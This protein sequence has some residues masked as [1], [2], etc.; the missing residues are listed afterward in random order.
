MSSHELIYVFSKKGA[1]YYRK[2]I[3]GDFAK[4]LISKKHLERRTLHAGIMPKILD[5]N[6]GRRCALSVIDVPNTYN[7]RSGF[8]HPTQKPD[9]LYKFLIER[10]SK[11]GDT[12]LDATAGSFTSVFVANTLERKAIGIEMNEE[13]F[14]QALLRAGTLADEVINSKCQRDS[15]EQ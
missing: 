7:K 5:D 13:F 8:H 6:T 14:K 11:E 2:D 4:S 12:V 15:S 3:T 9:D 10:Y 1:R